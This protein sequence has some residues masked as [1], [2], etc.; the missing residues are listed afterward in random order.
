MHRYILG[1]IPIHS[2]LSILQHYPIARSHCLFTF[3]ATRH[4]IARCTLIMFESTSS[5]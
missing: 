2:S 1:S 4:S 5:Y 3:P